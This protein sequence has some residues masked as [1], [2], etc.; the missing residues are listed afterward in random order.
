MASPPTS[1]SAQQSDA[2]SPS[3]PIDLPHPQSFPHCFPPSVPPLVSLHPRP[4]PRSSF[5]SLGY[6]IPCL[7][8]ILSST[9]RLATHSPSASF[10]PVIFFFHHLSPPHLLTP[11]SGSSP[12]DYTVFSPMCSRLHHTQPKHTRLPPSCHR[13]VAFWLR[14]RTFHGGA[15]SLVI[16]CGRGVQPFGAAIRYPDQQSKLKS[17]TPVGNP[18]GD[19]VGSTV[20]N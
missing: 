6:I 15:P 7:S 17:F 13:L 10:T 14:P 2:P 16:F 18:V 12:P 20:G 3:F 19:P 11:G 5:L 4:P 1:T 8:F 9:D